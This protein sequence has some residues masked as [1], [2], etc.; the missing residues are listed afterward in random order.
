MPF[1]LTLPPNQ[2]CRPAAEAPGKEGGGT[3]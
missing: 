1:P 2:D 3:S